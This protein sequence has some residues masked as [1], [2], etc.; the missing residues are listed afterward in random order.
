MFMKKYILLLLVL[1]TIKGYTQNNDIF[2]LVKDSKTDLVMS[3]V[4]I[5][6]LEIG[7]SGKT[8]TNGV[9]KLSI[10]TPVTLKISFQGYNDIEIRSELLNERLNIIYLDPSELTADKE[11]IFNESPYDILSKL[12]VNSMNS[13]ANPVSLEV[14]V[15]EFFKK[16]NSFSTFNDGLLKFYISGEPTQI[17]SDIIVNQ[18]RFYNIIE[19]N[20]NSNTVGYD[21]NSL[22][23][24]YYS[25][26]YLK[27]LLSEN[28]IKKYDCYYTT[29]S[30]HP[31]NFKIK[32]VLKDEV[33]EAMPNYEIVYDYSKMLIKQ[34]HSYIPKSK[35]VYANP[36]K[37]NF[38]RG[39]LLYSNFDAE[40]KI[41]NQSYYLAKAKEEVGVK[42]FKSD[43]KYDILEV[44]NLFVVNKMSIN[45]LIYNKKEVFKD[46]S[47]NKIKSKYYNNYWNTMNNVELSIEETNILKKLSSETLN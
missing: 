8:S 29:S 35:L 18:N 40:Y 17:K 27:Q 25:F 39:A 15:I 10:N 23:E 19:D 36:K 47:L 44:K 26:N 37:F 21:L 22:I 43:N 4:N 24:N 38:T 1:F 12:I 16:N 28:D 14:Y 31:S 41:E 13:L 46:K 3:Q 7:K 32:I 45:E 34:V 33:N 20:Q 6:A 2:I 11:I 30:T 5:M 9:F 42:E